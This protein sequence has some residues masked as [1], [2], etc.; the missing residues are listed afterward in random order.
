MKLVIITVAVLLGMGGL[1]LLS[2]NNKPANPDQQKLS[3]QTIQNELTTGAQ[4]IDVR[5]AEEYAAGH[6]QGATLLP[7]QDIQSGKMPMANKDKTVYVYCRSGNRSAQA[8]TILRNAGYTNVVDLG[9]M[10]SVESIGGTVTK[11]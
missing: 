10:T 4:L 11:S 1:F 7:L 6:I 5:T 9:A 2:N 8:A 3:F